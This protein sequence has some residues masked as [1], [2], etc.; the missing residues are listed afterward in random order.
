M[1][2]PSLSSSLQQVRWPASVCGGVHAV[3]TSRSLAAAH[4]HT[5]LPAASTSGGSPQW[6]DSFRGAPCDVGG[7]GGGDQASVS[8]LGCDLLASER[9]RA[10]PLPHPLAFPRAPPQCAPSPSHSSRPRSRARR[11]TF[12]A[13]TCRSVGGGGGGSGGGDGLPALLNMAQAP[14][15]A[16][17]R[18]HD[19]VEG[20]LVG[21]T[22]SWLGGAVGC[23]EG[24]EARVG[25]SRSTCA[26]SAC[27]TRSPTRCVPV[28]WC[29][30]TL[31]PCCCCWGCR[32]GVGQV[33]HQRS[34]TRFSLLRTPR[35]TPPTQQQYG[36][37][38]GRARCQSLG[39]GPFPGAAHGGGGGGLGGVRVRG[40]PPGCRQGEGRGVG[41]GV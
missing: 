5:P 19:Q 16:C 29:S 4:A 37:R 34:S 32:A 28:Q 15:P 2:A 13:R 23:G 39:A 24:R 41:G 31:C 7:G 26:P 17:P 38:R 25:R 35:A 10:A 9:R 33:Q 40:E 3:S 20:H 1:S 36:Q 14:P 27:T 18:A 8:R 21:C 22:S 30:G 12:R 11:W 6:S